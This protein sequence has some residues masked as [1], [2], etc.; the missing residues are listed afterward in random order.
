MKALKW[1][2]AGAF[3]AMVVINALAELLPIGGKTTGQ[4]SEAY[5]NLFTPAP[6]T[7]VIWGA[8]YLLMFLFVI[9]Q[10][11]IMDHGK[12]SANVRERIGIWFSIS[13]VLNILWIFLWHSQL[14]GLAVLCI[15]LLLGALGIIVDRL[16][17]P[18]P[19][20]WQKWMVNAGF[21][22]YFGWIIAAVIA[23]ISVYL[24]QIG[25]NGWGLSD[26]FWTVVILLAGS[27]IAGAASFRNRIAGIAVMWAYAGILIRHLSPVYY[28]GTHPYVIAAGFL[29]EMVILAA[30][31]IPKW[32]WSC[33]KRMPAA[34][35]SDRASSSMKG[36]S[37]KT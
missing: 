24:T 36:S 19:D 22:L 2:N 11:G 8:I 9:Y 29:S 32:L 30:I 17:S 3:A 28:G 13:C 21:S 33:R 16:M 12:E 18:K 10:F 34:C 37:V 35:R 1:I 23:N 15:I 31:M 4:I 25:W 7:F 26:D 5:P 14:I 6:V 27:L 20:I